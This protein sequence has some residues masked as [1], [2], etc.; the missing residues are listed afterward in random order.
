MGPIT[1]WGTATLVHTPRSLHPVPH[2]HMQPTQLQHQAILLPLLGRGSPN[3]PALVFLSTSPCIPAAACFLKALAG[4]ALP[5]EHPVPSRW[6]TLP[7]PPPRLVPQAP[8]CSWQLA[9]LQKPDMEVHRLLRT[10]RASCWVTAQP[11]LPRAH[12]TT[13]R[14]SENSPSCLLPYPPPIAMCKGIPV[15]SFIAD[16]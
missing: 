11:A 12:V 15:F 10:P 3:G 5:L 14:H 1:A 13:L 6:S 9:G 7:T 2:T 16:S 8:V 4:C